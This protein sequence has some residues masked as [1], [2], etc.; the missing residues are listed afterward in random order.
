MSFPPSPKLDV[1]NT[2]LTAFDT[3]DLDGIYAL[4][5]DDFQMELF[6]ASLGDH[7]MN[8]EQYKK[9]MEAQLA[10]FTGVKACVFCCIVRRESRADRPALIYRRLFLT[11]SRARTD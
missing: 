9:Y 2:W 4:L 11:L 8:L 10:S 6:P 1:V 7:V 5:T 3:W